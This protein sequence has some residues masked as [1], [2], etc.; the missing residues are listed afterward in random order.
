VRDIA[1]IVQ[2]FQHRDIAGTS[3]AC[4][5]F[6]SRARLL[7]SSYARAVAMPQRAMRAKD[8][9]RKTDERLSLCAKNAARQRA[10]ATVRPCRRRQDER[11]VADPPSDASQ[12]RRG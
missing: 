12:R 11:K 5:I 6:Q 7:F 8:L 3:G 2:R 10:R 1:P 4:R 9:R